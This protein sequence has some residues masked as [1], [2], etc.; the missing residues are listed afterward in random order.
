MQILES[1][2]LS[3]LVDYGVN[4]YEEQ[5]FVYELFKRFFA[6]SV[7]LKYGYL[8]PTCTDEPFVNPALLNT[9]LGIKPFATRLFENSVHQI[10]WSGFVQL[11]SFVILRKNLASHKFANITKLIQVQRPKDLD[12][13]LHLNKVFKNDDRKLT[14]TWHHITEILRPNSKLLF[15][16][17]RFNKL[18]ASGLL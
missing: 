1:I 12:D 16:S 17:G 7:E 15:L 6:K 3:L 2:D 11:L 13:D 5:I 8:K 9:E 18:R 10:S 4:S 14:E